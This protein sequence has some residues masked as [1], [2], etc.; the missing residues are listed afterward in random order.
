M[1]RTIRFQLFVWSRWEQNVLKK[2]QVI[3]LYQYTPKKLCLNVN[4]TCL[5]RPKRSIKKFIWKSLNG[6]LIDIYFSIEVILLRIIGSCLGLQIKRNDICSV[7]FLI[8]MALNIKF[9][10]KDK[11]YISVMIIVSFYTLLK[12]PFSRH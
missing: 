2:T 9:M 4:W 8:E 7:L 11:T 10:D 12:Y 6:I 5:N 1:D 3:E